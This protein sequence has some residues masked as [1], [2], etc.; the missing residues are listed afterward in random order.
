[1]VIEQE[2]TLTIS[3]INKHAIIKLSE[4]T[5]I[6]IVYNMEHPLVYLSSENKSLFTYISPGQFVRE[7][8]NVHRI[9]LI[10]KYME[11]L[12]LEGPSD[13]LSR[14]F[15]YSTK[16]NISK[17]DCLTLYSILHHVPT[18]FISDSFI[19]LSKSLD[20]SIEQSFDLYCSLLDLLISNQSHV[21]IVLYDFCFIYLIHLIPFG[22]GC[23]IHTSE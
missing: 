5:Q 8:L 13:A 4:D 18:E 12:K 3:E 22:V 21:L 17:K 11:I 16:D 19:S 20:L 10:S 6:H 2:T 23:A 1:M 9:D 14:V 7:C 15:W